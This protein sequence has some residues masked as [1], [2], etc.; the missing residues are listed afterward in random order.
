MS[1]N[2]WDETWHR[3]R[4]WTD[5]QGPSE[6]LAAQILLGEGFS[7]IDPSHPLGGKDGG[8]DAICLKNGERWIMAVYF[9][10]GEHAFNKIKAKFEGDLGGVVKNGVKGIAFVTNQEIRLAER[11]E[12]HQVASPAVLELFHLERLTTI[13]DSPPM[14]DV[15]KQFLGVDYDDT[16]NVVFGGEGGK[17]PGAGGGGGGALGIGARGGDGGKGGKVRLAGTPGQAPGAGGGGG[18]VIG[19]GATGGEGGEGGELVIGTFLA[20]DLPP[21]VEI[22][23]GRGGKGNKENGDGMDGEDTTFGD[24]LRAKGGRGGRAGKP[25]PA[26]PAVLADV[27][28]GLHV[29]SIHLAECVHIRDGL[30]YLLGA[31]WE[32]YRVPKLPFKVRWPLVCTVSMGELP[33]GSMLELCAA[34]MDPTGTEVTRQNFNA[35]RGSEGSISRPSYS[36]ALEFTVGQK[37]IWTITVGSGDVQLAQLPVEVKLGSL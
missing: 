31:G 16:K 17:A 23:V 32:Y 24:L 8:R 27:D 3:L 19:D 18:G 4:N 15:R 11:E 12:L 34:V 1:R 13:L 33:L 36:I 20:K 30:L 37:G 21:T 29:S 6:R 9:P 14:A 35:F 2:R 25:P 5:G 10:R 26:R 28:K 7:S 22:K